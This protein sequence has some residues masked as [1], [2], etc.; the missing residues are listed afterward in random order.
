MAGH[1]LLVPRNGSAE[2]MDIS[3]MSNKPATPKMFEHNFVY[4]V[5]KG[6]SLLGIAKRHDV[7]VGQIRS[8]NGGIGR[9]LLVGQELMLRQKSFD[10]LPLISPKKQVELTKK[11]M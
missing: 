10:K 7:T 11:Q 3:V 4:A 6:D 9:L 5:K 1:V 2:G 8:W